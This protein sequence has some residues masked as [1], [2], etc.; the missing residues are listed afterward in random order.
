MT[1]WISFFLWICNVVC[2]VIIITKN[3]GNTYHINSKHFFSSSFLSL[4]CNEISQNGRVFFFVFF[5][6]MHLFF[7]KA[8]MLLC[9]EDEYKERKYDKWNSTNVYTTMLKMV[10]SSYQSRHAWQ[11]RRNHSKVYMTHSNRNEIF[12]K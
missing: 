1:L 11:Q 10:R 3:N 7:A 6:Y 12:V 4:L 2:S 5:D 8:C 9:F